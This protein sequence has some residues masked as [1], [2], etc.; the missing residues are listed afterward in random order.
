MNELI[1]FLRDRFSEEAY[2]LGYGRYADLKI[3]YADLKIKWWVVDRLAEIV[4]TKRWPGP[5]MRGELATLFAIAQKYAAVY[6]DH[7]D[8]RPEKWDDPALTI[9]LWASESTVKLGVGS[10]MQSDRQSA[11]Q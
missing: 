10:V 7:E 4:D 6:G 8:Y 5:R 1:Q 11:G 3:R 9:C 2:L